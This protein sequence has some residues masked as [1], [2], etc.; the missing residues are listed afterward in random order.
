LN[1]FSCVRQ[2]PTHVSPRVPSVPHP[3]LGAC[4]GC[5]QPCTSKWPLAPANEI[6]A[7]FPMTC[8]HTIV[9]ASHCVGLTWV[10]H[11]S[12]HTDM[13]IC[14]NALLWRQRQTDLARHDGRPRLILWE[15]QLAQPA[16]RTRACPRASG[17]YLAPRCCGRGRGCI[18][19]R[20]MSLAILNRDTASTL[21]AP[22]ASTSASCV[23]SASNLF[24]AVS[25]GRPVSAAIS[26]A[27]ATSKPFL[28]FRP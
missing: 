26:L 3:A 27:T 17:R 14:A 13:S 10:P 8:V 23:A 12:P 18:P 25:N 11:A 19:R 4:V 7:L 9:S 24:G 22:C 1:T 28:V 6:V 5:A 16:A 2:P 15:E 21:S 20:R